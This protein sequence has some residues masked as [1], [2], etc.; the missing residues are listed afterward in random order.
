MEKSVPRNIINY[1]A[2]TKSVEQIKHEKI[3]KRMTFK[4]IIKEK[5]NARV[6]VLEN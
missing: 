3:M 4:K 1:G 2:R 5:I 6:I